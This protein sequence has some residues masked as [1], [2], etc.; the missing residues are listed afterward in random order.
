M[1]RLSKRLYLS[2][3]IGGMVGSII[4]IVLIFMGILYALSLA[5]VLPGHFPNP[6]LPSTGLLEIAILVAFLCLAAM[7]L[8]V[9]MRYMLIYRAWEAIQDGNARTTPGKAVGFLFIPFYNLYWIFQAWYGFAQDYNSYIE[10]HSI[11][12][13]KLDRGLFLAYSILYICSAIPYLNYL[14]L[15]PLIVIYIITVNAIINAVNAL[16]VGLP[17]ETA[18]Q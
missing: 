15:L 2:S 14:A 7:L 8:G 6:N 17:V 5:G 13:S 18:N 3:I 16:P 12:A 9:V 11:A 10:R 4:L 1:K